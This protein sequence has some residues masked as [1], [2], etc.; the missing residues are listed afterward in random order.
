MNDPRQPRRQHGV[1]DE[2][3]TLEVRLHP[4]QGAQALVQGFIR[5]NNDGTLT[6]GSLGACTMLAGRCMQPLLGGAA[7]WSRLQ[8][9]A[10]ALKCPLE[11]GLVVFL[12]VT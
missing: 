10:H 7:L 3:T 2:A 9:V 11:R 8:A 4:E 6:V 5:A 12:Q 1:E